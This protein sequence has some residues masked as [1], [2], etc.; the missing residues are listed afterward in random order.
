MNFEERFIAIDRA[1][2]AVTG[3]NV[4]GDPKSESSSRLISLSTDIVYVLRYHLMDQ[5]EMFEALGIQWTE[6][7]HMFCNDRGKPYHPSSVSHAFKRFTTR[8]GFPNVRL[9]DARHG[10][11]TILMKAEV[12]PK[13]VQKRLGHSTIAITMDIYSHVLREMDVVAAEAFDRQSDEF[14]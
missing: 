11:A 3:G 12:Q 14:R 9:H 5:M 6:D 4:E 2:V 1:R 8:A 7:F 13:V 10:H